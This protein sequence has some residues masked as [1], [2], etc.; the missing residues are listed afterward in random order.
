MKN[1]KIIFIIFIAVSLLLTGCFLNKLT[2]GLIPDKD[3]NTNVSENNNIDNGGGGSNE[4]TGG[5]GNGGTNLADIDRII[6]SGDYMKQEVLVKMTPSANSEQI[7]ETING[8]ILEIIPEISV[9]RVLLPEDLSIK[10]AI[11]LLSESNLVQYAEP[12]GLC[13]LFD[14]PT[15]PNDRYYKNQ[16]APKI[17]GLE[18]VWEDPSIRGKGIIIAITDTGVDGTHPDLA[19]KVIAGWDT[20]MNK[21][22]PAGTNSDINGHGTHCAGIAVATGNNRIGIAGVA[23]EA[24]IMPVQMSNH[25]EPG[26]VSWSNMA[27][28]FVWA[29]DNDADI[30]SCSAGGKGYSQTMKDA[31]DFALGKGCSF[32]AA[33]GNSSIRETAYPA[34]YQGVI[35]V[36][37]TDGHDRIA[38]FSTTG[39]HMSVC[40]PGAEIYSTMPGNKYTYMSGTSMA[41]PF[42]AGVAALMLEQDDSL[43]LYDIKSRLENSAKIIDG[44]YKRVDAWAAIN[45]DSYSNYGSIRVTVTDKNDVPL[46]EV[47][48]ILWQG[49]GVFSTTNSNNEGIAIFEYILA[50]NYGVS[51]SLPCLTPSLAVNNQVTVEAG[52][53][54]EKSIKFLEAID[55][56]IE[57]RGKMTD[58]YG[59]AYTW[60]RDENSSAGSNDIHAKI[61]EHGL[62]KLTGKGIPKVDISNRD[63]SGILLPKGNSDVIYWIEIDFYDWWSENPDT[64]GYR[65]YR[66]I[67]GIDDDYIL[68]EKLGRHDHWYFDDISSS[69]FDNIYNYRIIAYGDCWE[70]EP[71]EPV[72]I[73][74]LPPC[75]LVSPPNGA[76][77]AESNPTFT[78]NPA[79][80]SAPYGSIEYLVSCLRVYDLTLG[81]YFLSIYFDDATTSTIDYDPNGWGAISLVS[82]HEYVWYFKAYGYDEDWNLIAESCS[83]DWV[84]TFDD[85]QPLTPGGLAY[86]WY[87]WPYSSQGFNEFEV[88]LTIDI[89]P[90]AQS[91]YYWAHQFPFKDGDGG[92]MGLQIN[93]YISGLGPVGKMAIFSIWDALDAE[94]GPGAHCEEFGGEGE[95]WSCRKQF[96][97]VEGHTYGLR[98][99]FEG[100]DEQ[101]NKWWGAYIIDKTISEETFLGKI[102]VPYNWKG[103]DNS[104]VWVEYYGEV[105][106]CRAIPH[107]KVRF[108]QPMAD[109]E[110]APES[111][112][113]IYGERCTNSSITIIGNT[114]VI[115]ETGKP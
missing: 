56:V 7:A 31:V 5:T 10:E 105:N 46:S 17:T 29:A 75:S 44:G 67:D 74:W 79:G 95:G 98:V 6:A 68:I 53:L 65:I 20:Y 11:N 100:L 104:V 70:T 59:I 82:G 8:E 40:A 110:Y 78:W 109:N 111:V 61:I 37:A 32:F 69:P 72:T 1:L 89:D 92:Y 16:W 91:A 24:Q 62:T 42:V 2:D 28:A 51:A 49:E 64:K 94:A 96:N 77:V 108:E 60:K 52:E 90:G 14:S 23:W 107:A 27:K 99:K 54:A 45:D 19:G 106:G 39:S 93:G 81:S 15:V 73:T 26:S 33:M 66:K 21:P 38:S 4:V 9:V 13:F 63:L 113:P 12:N 30:I 47:S 84:F 80:I 34:G 103:L 71:S 76:I 86:N 36:G 18:E 22:I 3:D 112:Y 35:A 50:G 41:C 43:T 83:E 57:I 115:F 114:G 101:Q 55:N 85:Q 25:F 102:K 88:D 97:W 87:N 58:I 48:V